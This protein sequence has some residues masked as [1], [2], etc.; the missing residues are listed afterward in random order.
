MVQ[1]F[2]TVGAMLRHDAEKA[3]I[4]LRTLADVQ[5]TITVCKRQN[6]DATMARLMLNHGRVTEDARAWLS[7]EYPQ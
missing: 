2:E 3:G 5:S 7:Q 4:P 6:S 1:K